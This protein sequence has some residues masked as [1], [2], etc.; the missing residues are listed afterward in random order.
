MKKIWVDIKKNGLSTH[1]N[2][3]SPKYSGCQIFYKG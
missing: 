1:I 2:D 3:A